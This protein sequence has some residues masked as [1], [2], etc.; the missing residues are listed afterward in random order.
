MSRTLI[1][2]I[3]IGTSRICAAAAWRDQIGNYEIAAIDRAVSWLRKKRMYRRCRCYCSS[4][5]ESCT[6]VE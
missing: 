5:Q 1:C 6:Q 4:H 2:A 3:Q